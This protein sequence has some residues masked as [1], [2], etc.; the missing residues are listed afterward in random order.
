MDTDNFTFSLPTALRS[1]RFLVRP[2][3][4]CHVLHECYLPRPSLI[5][6]TTYGKQYKLRSFTWTALRTRDFAVGSRRLTVWVT[7]RPAIPYQHIRRRVYRTFLA[8]NV[9][10]RVYRR[11]LCVTYRTAAHQKPGSEDVGYLPM[12]QDRTLT[13]NTCSSQVRV[14]CACLHHSHSGSV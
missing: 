1:S 14:A 9:E 10:R 8:E 7:A 3:R 12:V 6:L 11:T 2:D 5:I 13:P 4:I